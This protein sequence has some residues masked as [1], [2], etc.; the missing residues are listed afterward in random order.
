PGALKRSISGDVVDLSLEERNGALD[1][2]RK[3]LAGQPFVREMDGEGAELRLYVERGEEAL[4]ALLR[5]L[6]G[7]GLSV[8]GISLSR[9][10]L[11][12]VF[13]RQTG[14]SLR[15]AESGDGQ[16]MEGAEG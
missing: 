1:R 6:D 12:D 3:L 2:A 13:L 8:R 11:D 15:E 10:T 5:L 9:P 14:R 7:A 4:P 16:H